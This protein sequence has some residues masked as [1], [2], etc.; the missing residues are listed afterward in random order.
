MKKI[1]FFLSVKQTTSSG[2]YNTPTP[3]QQ[4]IPRWWHDGESFISGTN[5]QLNVKDKSDRHSGMKACI[6]YL[7]ALTSGYMFLTW[8]DVEIVRNDSG[9]VVYRYVKKDEDGNWIEDKSNM[10]DIAPLIEERP[11]TLGYTM[12]RPQGYS[13]NHMAWK[14]VWGWGLPRGWST[15]VTHPFNRFDL[16]FITLS[17]IVD[18]DN[19]RANGNIPFHL[20]DGWTG[21]IEKGTPFAQ[22]IPIKRATWISFYYPEL[23]KFTKEVVDKL[24]RI[25]GG[26][27]RKNLWVKK[28]YLT[29]KEGK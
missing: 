6:P 27:Y 23:D 12:P 16:P 17:A 5:Y 13:F 18:S 10:H 11:Q 8:R 29:E 21:I 15:L 1:S 22:L 20:K 4:M 14:N 7:D 28:R 9:V 2:E 24:R 26:Y 3:A 25:T 19:F